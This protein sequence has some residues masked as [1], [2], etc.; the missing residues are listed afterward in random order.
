M[1]AI[2]AGQEA[3]Q[4]DVCAMIDLRLELEEARAALKQG[5]QGRVQDG[6]E[7]IPVI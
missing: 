2:L 3:L 6:S 5:E 4:S 1:D 7:E